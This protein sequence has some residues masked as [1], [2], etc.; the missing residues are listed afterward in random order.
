[1]KMM[2]SVKAGVNGTVK[3]VHYASG[4]SVSKGDLIMLIEPEA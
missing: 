4:D 1:M 3:E 2:N